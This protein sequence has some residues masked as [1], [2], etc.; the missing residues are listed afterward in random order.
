MRGRPPKPTKLHIVQGTAR[1]DRMKRRAGEP[2]PQPIPLECPDHLKA[3]A[4]K[5]WNWLVPKLVALGVGTEID[6]DALVAYCRVYARWDRAEKKLDQE[7]DT[8]TSP[9]G[10]IMPSP[11]LA[12]A[13][14][15]LEQMHKFLTEFGMTASSR[16]RVKVGGAA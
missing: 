3:E 12:I 2:K 13:N 8:V 11:Y 5:E 6:R 10:Y 15:A 14:K 4:R 9:N 1:P 16:T 7:G